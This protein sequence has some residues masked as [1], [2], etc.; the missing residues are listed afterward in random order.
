[1][2]TDNKS[3]SYLEE[4]AASRRLLLGTKDGHLHTEILKTKVADGDLSAV[5]DD[6]HW[7]DW[8]EVVREMRGSVILA[9]NC[10]EARRS[11][12]IAMQSRYRLAPPL[13]GQAK[14]L[15]FFAPPVWYV[16]RRQVEMMDPDYW[17]DPKNTLREALD[18]PWWTTVPASLIRG[19]LEKHLGRAAPETQEAANAG[20]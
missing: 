8:Q 13:S 15:H 5:F 17:N 6:D 12:E 9:A 3:P 2:G 11:T 16:L 1:M 18:C 19:E 7:L 10:A 4:R 20:G 14:W